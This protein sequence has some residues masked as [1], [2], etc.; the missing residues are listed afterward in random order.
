MT[1]W[2]VILIVDLVTYSLVFSV[3]SLQRKGLK[4]F[5]QQEL[6][7]NFE[8]PWD[9]VDALPKEAQPGAE[10]LLE[11]RYTRAK[12]GKPRAWN[13]TVT[14]PW[15]NGSITVAFPPDLPDFLPAAGGTI[16]WPE[17]DTRSRCVVS[18]C[19]L[20]EPPTPTSTPRKTGQ[21]TTHIVVDDTSTPPRRRAVSHAARAATQVDLYDSNDSYDDAED[22]PRTPRPRKIPPQKRD[23]ETQPT[24]RPRETVP[25]TIEAL[26]ASI[27][28]DDED[29]DDS[30]GIMQ[31]LRLNHP[32]SGWWYTEKGIGYP[33]HPSSEWRWAYAHLWSAS[34][35]S[36]WESD[37]RHSLQTW[38]RT[39]RDHEMSRA[40]N[41]IVAQMAGTFV[42]WLTRPDDVALGQKIL[43]GII[44][45]LALAKGGTA[46][47][48]AMADLMAE[49]ETR[50]KV[51]YVA[52]LQKVPPK[53]DFPYPAAE[54]PRYPR[55]D[56][57]RRS[58]FPDRRR[59]QRKTY[60]RKK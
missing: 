42:A 35:I 50:G 43:E 24:K 40:G 6:M 39:H 12:G 46:G 11:W 21:P 19:T 29:N 20:R 31:R 10:L 26:I 28:D 14:K 41:L 38:E 52:L 15:K 45:Q 25:S 5:K 60:F 44:L 57:K 23:R 59:D 4:G 22:A 1:K 51:S 53:K 9:E 30:D 8:L 18:R 55:H 13:G 36:R 58:D 48:A 32:H 16:R 37:F 2:H 33:K 49:A 7:D 34:D 54:E 17:P 27:K 47:P 56:D 3:L